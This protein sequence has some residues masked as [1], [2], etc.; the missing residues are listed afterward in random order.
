MDHFSK[1]RQ[2][3]AIVS[4]V[5]LPHPSQKMKSFFIEIYHMTPNRKSK[6]L[7]ALSHPSQEKFKI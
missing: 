3:M 7:T 2:F 6:D 1:S 5:L 4:G